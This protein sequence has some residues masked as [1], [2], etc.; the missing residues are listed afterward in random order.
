MRKNSRPLSVVT[1]ARPTNTAEQSAA[2]AQWV[3]A[4]PSLIEDGVVRWRR[5]DLAARIVRE[6]GV[7]LAER[8]VGDLLHRLGFRRVSVR[9]QHPNQDV[10]A[11]EAHKKTSPN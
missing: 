10:E 7:T 6:Y 2:V 4:G 3:R 1:P 8:S 9:P 5:I 11:L